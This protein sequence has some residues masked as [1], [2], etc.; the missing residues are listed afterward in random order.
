MKTAISIPDEL[1]ARAEATAKRL[2]VSRSELYSKAIAEFVDRAI[3][4]NVTEQLNHVYGSHK[5]QL[6][7]PFYVAQLQSIDPD[8]W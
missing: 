4:Q 3:E 5:A 2:Q 8:A 1:F 7:S 6:E